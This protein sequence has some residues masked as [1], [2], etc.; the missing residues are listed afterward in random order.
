MIGSPC[1]IE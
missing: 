1:T